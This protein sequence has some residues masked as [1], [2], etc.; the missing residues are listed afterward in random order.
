MTDAEH[1]ETYLLNLQNSRRT[2][3]GLGVAVIVL[4]LVYMGTSYGLMYAAAY[5][6]PEI[7]GQWWFNWVLNLVPLYV[8]ALPAFL[9]CLR[10]VEKGA[11]DCEYVSRGFVYD[12]P[13]FHFG[14]WCL[15][16]L[17]GFGYMYIGN[18]I[19]NGLM[20]WM[21]KLTGYDYQNG[22][23]SLAD[24]SPWWMIL[25]GTVIIA[26]IGEEFMFRKLF[27]DRARRY[28]DGM[29]ILLSAL[30]FALFHGNFF[31][32]FYAFLL[33][34][35]MGYMYTLSGKLR[36]PVALHM[37][38]NFMGM[39][40]M[41]NLLRW[42]GLEALTEI[43]PSDIDALDQLITSN[44]LGYEIYSM[45]SMMFFGAM[46]ASIVLTIIFLCKRKIRL[47]QGEVPLRR[48][49]RMIAAF[50]NK[51]MPVCIFLLC[52]LMVMNLIIV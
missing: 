17:I 28:G 37:F 29:A 14:F 26:P 43:D 1:R 4:L 51:G 47:G 21:S 35:V 15:L 45:I 18:Y 11:H 16:A 10:H 48:E 8:F 40:V 33:G 44:P 38:I 36:W 20:G 19:G 22:L 6:F 13:K 3:S 9:L 12:K 2:Y 7:Y 39:M 49:D 46:I 5:L 30:L 23:S 25:L 52:L 32:F 34:L 27:I 50:G 41:P 42:L 31:Q 24:S